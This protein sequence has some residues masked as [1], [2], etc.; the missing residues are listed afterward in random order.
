MVCWN[1]NSP[2]VSSP[3]RQEGDENATNLNLHACKPFHQ[4]HFATPLLSPIRYSPSTISLLGQHHKGLN[5]P[6]LAQDNL[7]ITPDRSSLH[8]NRIQQ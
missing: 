4:A 5:P 1:R 7:T 3:S 8:V 6:D 2:Y